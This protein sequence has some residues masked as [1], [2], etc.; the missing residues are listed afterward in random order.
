MQDAVGLQS[1]ALSVALFVAMLGYRGKD[2]ALFAVALL[3]GAGFAHVGW[4]VLHADLVLTDPAAWIDPTR[5][6]S[7]LFMPLGPC[8]LGFALRSKDERRRF[9]AEALRALPLALACARLGCLLAGCCGGTSLDVASWDV[10]SSGTSDGGR[11]LVRVRH[12]TAIYEM[13]ALVA[14]H[15]RTARVRS[16]QVFGGFALGFGLIRLA[17]EPFRAA[18]PLGPPRVPVEWVAAAWVFTGLASLARLRAEAASTRGPMERS[19]GAGRRPESGRL[20]RPS[21]P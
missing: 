2:R 19:R 17:V 18:D 21:H 5:G 6:L 20:S 8:L 15:F 7:V 4:A 10:A 11:L 14:L 9:V 12:P 16:E 1:S 13:V 3:V